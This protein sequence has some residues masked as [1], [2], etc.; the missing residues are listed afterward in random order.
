MC[1]SLVVLAHK[2]D[3]APELDEVYSNSD[4]QPGHFLLQLFL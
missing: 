4:E 2:K 1:R 3:D